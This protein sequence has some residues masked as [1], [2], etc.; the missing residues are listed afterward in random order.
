MR[1]RDLAAPAAVF[2]VALCAFAAA[3]VPG[4]A[5]LDL[6][7]YY[8][9]KLAELVGSQGP[10]VDVRWLP[11]TVLGDH[12]TD[13][14]WLWHVLLAPFTW[15]GTSFE[16]LK[17]AI[18]IT[19][20]FVPAALFVVARPMSVPW[21]ALV[22]ALGVTGALIMPGRLAVLCAQNVAVPLLAIAL[23][24]MG[25]RRSVLLGVTAFIFMQTYHGAAVLAP[26]ALLRSSSCSRCSAAWTSVRSS[27]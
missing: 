10:W 4:K 27:P 12:G 18:A 5:V 1:W 8:H 26:L 21:A 22:A 6:D 17:W 7:A 13:H 20:A 14:H 9:F 2:T 3:V 24:A 23:Y 11:F 25:A 16:V 19:A 15:F